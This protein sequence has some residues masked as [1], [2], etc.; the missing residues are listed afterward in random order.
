MFSF[1]ISIGLGAVVGYCYGLFFITKQKKAF[2][3]QQFHN[4]K[5]QF[6]SFFC[7]S[8]GR[9]LLLCFFLGYVLRSSMIHSILL[10]ISFI[11]AFWFIIL[12]KKVYFHEG[13]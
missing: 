5:R 9:F 13:T 11:G 10:L 12:K 2:F 3:I 7:F 8:V 6:I 4:K 1:F